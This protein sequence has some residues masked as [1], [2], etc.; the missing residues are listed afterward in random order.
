MKRLLVVF[1]S[2]V[3]MLSANAQSLEQAD[4]L[5][6][7]GKYDDAIGLYTTAVSLLAN[8]PAKRS[9]VTDKVKL[10]KNCKEKLNK[11]DA[12]YNKHEYDR[13]VA[14]YKEVLSLNPKDPKAKRRI[15]EIPSLKEKDKF[16]DIRWG[17]VV[18]ANTLESYREYVAEYP[19]GKHI[20]EAN[21]F[22]AAAE[23]RQREAERAAEQERARL[24]QLRQ[25]EESAYNAFVN[26]RNVQKGL[27]YLNE[28]SGHGT[29][30]KQVKDLLVEV[31]CDSHDFDKANMYAVDAKAKSYVDTHKKAYLR[32][33]NAKE[34]AKAFDAFDK[35]KTEQAAKSFIDKYPYGNHAG[36][37]SAWLVGELCKKKDFTQA[38]N[39][40]LTDDLKN[41]IKEH[42]EESLFADIKSS[43]NT[44]KEKLYISNYKNGRH[45]DE[46]LDLYVKDLIDAAKFDE[47]RKLVA[48]DAQRSMLY[49]REEK[50]YYDA[51]KAKPTVQA[52]IQTLQTLQQR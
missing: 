34:E 36:E 28:Y 8:D 32:E 21:E 17:E 20:A 42:E 49:D 46:V 10:C 51:Y 33:L 6:D 47:A 23:E 18:A 19:A 52:G 11:A 5:F 35:N 38:K 30:E 4:K 13:A 29:Y 3:C 7:S 25:K 1:L 27:D 41:S 2:F 12:A 22:I 39:Y 16:D 31:F 43:H 15:S 40:A 48:T 50:F 14:A 45:Y 26:T 44:I 37:V 24:E 9:A